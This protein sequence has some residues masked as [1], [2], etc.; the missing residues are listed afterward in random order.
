[1]SA[2]VEAIKQVR[3]K[4]GARIMKCRRAINASGGDIEKA[5][6]ILKEHGLLQARKREEREANE[7]RLF[8][9]A[10]G[11]KAVLVRLA[12]ETDFVARNAD[13]VRLGRE[14]VNI[15]FEAAGREDELSDRIREAVGRIRENIVL[16][17]VE[18]L[19]AGPAFRATIL[20]GIA[21][22]T[23]QRKPLVAHLS[24]I[25]YGSEVTAALR[26]GHAVVIAKPRTVAVLIDDLLGSRGEREKGDG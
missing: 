2:I 19:S 5:A 11:R 9:K 14:W 12:C 22:W 6:A 21:V 23:L 3:V 17:S 24:G 8:L 4:T 18:I 25:S 26:I 10:D 20:N 16:R 7:G 1:M 15:A 13:F